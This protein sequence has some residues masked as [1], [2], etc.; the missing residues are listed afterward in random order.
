MATRKFRKL[1]KVKHSK[2]L[3]KHYKTL[4]KKVHKRRKSRKPRKPRKSRKSR[5]PRKSHKMRGG[6][7]HGTNPLIGPPWN[8]SN[9]AHYYGLSKE[10]IGVG[11]S[12]PFPGYKLQLSHRVNKSPIVQRGGNLWQ[13]IT[14]ASRNTRAFLAQPINIFKGLPN[15]N[16]P[17]PFV[18]NKYKTNLP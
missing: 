10:P 5:K 2:Y 12:E 3:R 16:S 6:F 13:I 11:G 4:A 18:Q 7:G 17:M 1:N 14:N 9:D 8:A 15:D